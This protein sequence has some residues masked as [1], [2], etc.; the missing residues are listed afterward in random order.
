MSNEKAPDSINR[1]SEAAIP[2]DVLHIG[3]EIH[4]TELEKGPNTYTGHGWTQEEADKNAGDN[5]RKG[6]KD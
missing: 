1:S 4:K 5:Y 2:G 6:E 3:P